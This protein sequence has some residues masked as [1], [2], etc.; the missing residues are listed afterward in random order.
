[1]PSA[2]VEYDGYFGMGYS[3]DSPYG[4]LWLSS[5]ILPN[6]QVTGRFVSISGI[7]GFTD[8]PGEFGSGYGRYKDKVFDVKAKLWGE[9]ALLPSVAIGATDVLGTQ[10]FKGQYVV[11][12]KTFGAAKNVELSVG[13]GNKRPDGLFAGARWRPAGM[14]N[15][16]VVAEYD[17]NDYTRDYRALAT[18][19]AERGKGGP[20]VGLEYRWGWLGAQVARHRDH[21]SANM[22][23]SVPLGTRQFLPQLTEPPVFKRKD[24]APRPTLA[25]WEASPAH[26]AALVQALAK[27][28]YKNIRVALEGTTLNLTLNN[29]RISNLGRAVG[30]A[31]GTALAFA[32]VGVQ[33]MRITYTKLDQPIATYEI[34]DTGKLADYFNGIIGREAFL[35]TVVVRY[36]RPDDRIA[37]GEQGLLAG[38][39]DDNGLGFH[40]GRDGNIVQLSSEDRESNRFK[41][42][43]KIGF[44]FNDPGGAL[45]YEVAALGTYDRKLADGLFLSG[46]VK[47]NLI[48]DISDATQTSNSLLP[49]V[50]SDI[51][52]YRRG[53]KFQLN[54][55]MLNKY[56]Q[57]S[58]RV[59][60]RVSAGLYE[61]MFRGAGG[62]IM[63]LPRDSRWVADLSVDALEQRGYKGWFDKR[64]YRTVTA[65]GALHYR[66]PYDMTVTA[67][68]GQ[69]LA[70]DRGVRLEFKRRFASGIELGAWYTKTNGNDITSPG[71]PSDPYNDKGIFM[72]IPLRA[73][74]TADTQANAGFYLAP[75]TRDVGQM[76]ASPGDLYDM[77]ENPRRDMTSY[78]GLGNFAERADEQNLAAVNPPVRTFGNVWPRFNARIEQSAGASPGVPD[79]ARGTGLAAGAILA[80]ALLDKPADRYLKPRQD[81]GAMRNLGKFGKNMPMVLAGAAGAALAFGDERA[82]NTGIIAMQSVAASVGLAYGGKYLVGRARPDEERGPWERVGDGRSRAHAAFPSGHSAVAFAAV[83]PFAMEYDAPWL[84]GVAA[85]ASVGRVADRQHWVSDVVAGGVIGY[86]VGGWLWNNQRKTPGS[87]LSIVPGLKSVSVAY[88]KTY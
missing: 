62:Q 76:V 42:V 26:G 20:A 56:T 15:W 81:D 73:M 52:E 75:W 54:R 77:I 79:W 61:E 69:F 24:A 87:S 29:S 36:A 1:M 46:A 74:L 82:Q 34:R 39:K 53:N 22:Y 55:L 59:Y 88:Q 18:G 72:S 3:Y 6:L 86:A 66:L 13:Y 17:G 5:T 71:S 30:R 35:Q 78:D 12:T 80:S 47:L 44:L 83:T 9:T 7:R 49:H 14:P 67:R 65:L 37:D 70:K 4:A 33:S 27:Q 28:N 10:L 64:D 51:A 32:P 21:F 25:Q 84:Y 45:R 60:T 38:I 68:A 19:A 57:L 43:P 41:I 63:Y 40:A 11:A 85:L 8:V 16:A 23:V 50:R 48:E 58:E 2:S 31:S